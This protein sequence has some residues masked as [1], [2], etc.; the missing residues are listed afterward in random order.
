MTPIWGLTDERGKT[1]GRDPRVQPRTVV[2]DP[3]LTVSLPP[4]VTAASGMNA[5]AHCVEALYAPDASPVTT[6][7][8]AEGIRALAG[9]LPGAVARPGDVEARSAALYG[10]WLA[11]WVLGTTSMG[12]HHKLAHVLGGTYGLPH[13]GVHSALL[14]YVAAF[15]APAAPEALARVAGALA[16]PDAGG[17]LYDLAVALGAPTS[18]AALGL[19]ADVVDDIASTVVAAGVANPRALDVGDVRA[20]LLAAHA[21]ER[22]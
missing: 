22:P 12:L 10:A 8:A 9:S 11:G 17:G 18:L 4:D 3:A 13:G 14:P 6:L 5:L 19:P 16:T 7:L 1:T 20:L 2:Y 21:G 15:N